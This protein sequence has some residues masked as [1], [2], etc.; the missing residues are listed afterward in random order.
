MPVQVATF[1]R[2]VHLPDHADLQP[3]IKS[4]AQSLG[5]MGTLLLAEEGLNATLS[6]ESE[7]LQ[8][9]FQ[10]LAQDPR[11]ANLE[12]K[13]AEAPDH[14]FSRLRV[15]RKREIVTLRQPQ[16][17]PDQKVG[18][19]LDPPEWDDKIQD[20]ETIVVDVRNHYE[21][22]HG[23]FQNALD[24]QTEAF[25]EFPDW[26]KENLPD[27]SKPVAMF[28]TGG[29]RCEKATAYLLEQ[30][31]ENVYHLRGGILKYLEETP[32]AKSLYQGTCFVFDHRGAVDQN[33]NPTG[34]N[35]QLKQ[36]NARYKRNEK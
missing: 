4:L 3:Q 27:K 7:N 19:Y 26:V 1:Y 8:T 30:G 29:I 12:I 36:D 28:C 23:T 33:L 20:P 5:I 14:P 6:G 11:L 25:H 21:T 24:P 16:A 10:T 35:H 32:A 18:T 9:F 17:R 34:P 22:E 2:F 13:T 15:R 31:Y